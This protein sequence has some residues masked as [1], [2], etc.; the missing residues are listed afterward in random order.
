MIRTPE[1]TGVLLSGGLDSRVTLGTMVHEFGP[2][3]LTCTYG[4]TET[5]DVKTGREIA[6]ALGCRHEVLALQGDPLVDLI[7][8][9][10]V[11]DF[12]LESR[13]AQGR[14]VLRFTRPR[15]RHWFSGY[16]L[17]ATFG[18]YWLAEDSTPRDA[19]WTETSI[20]DR[21]IQEDRFR[22][23]VGD[24]FARTALEVSVE[25][26][27]AALAAFPETTPEKAFERFMIS[28]RHRGFHIASH[29]MCAPGERNFLMCDADLFD[30]FLSMPAHM[31]RDRT[32]YAYML[33]TRWPE[34]AH[35]RY[36]NTGALVGDPASKRYLAKRERSRNL[37][38]MARHFGLARLLGPSPYLSADK[39]FTFA[40]NAETR[41]FIER[42]LLSERALSRPHVA[43]HGVRQLVDS[44]QRS[45]SGIRL[46]FRLLRTELLI[47]CCLEGDGE[48]FTD[49]GTSWH[50]A[51]A[52]DRTVVTLPQTQATGFLS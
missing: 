37:R 5:S 45:A 43:P 23:V 50:V 26:V 28:F 1:Q 16:L 49:I 27:R 15:A 7:D 33:R 39:A 38:R 9:L 25:G 29:A 30:L 21:G 48:I 6:A 32:V 19:Q 52:D 17:D 34:I 13:N 46:L 22:A 12:L 31:R 18:G 11:S 35:V 4:L 20:L 24:A 40:E 36:S 47:R 51:A 10:V 8:S 3:P 41:R 14:E 44:L 42:V 2:A